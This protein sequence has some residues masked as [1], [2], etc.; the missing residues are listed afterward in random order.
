MVKFLPFLDFRPSF[1]KSYI[2][3][4]VKVPDMEDSSYKIPVEFNPLMWID[5]KT[6]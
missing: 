3:I 2:H 5:C 4:L 1:D 6:I